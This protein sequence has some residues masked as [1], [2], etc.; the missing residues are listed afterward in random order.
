MEVIEIQID[1]QQV[2]SDG[3]FPLA[4]SPKSPPSIPD[5][6]KWVK[7][8]HA[9]ISE[10]LIKHGAILFRGFNIV[11]AQDFYDFLLAFNWPF[12][13]YTGGGGPRKVVL[14]PIET[15]TETPPNFLIPF[16]HE[17]AYITTFPG[18]VCFY[19]E[20]PTEKDGET[21]ILLSNRIYKRMASYLLGRLS[22]TFLNFSR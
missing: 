18:K 6:T 2:N 16:H 4:L 9:K 8:N 20:L 7:D 15:S 11:G 22:Y 19:C 10:Q 13:S 14:G 21:P 3:I 12:G 5:I 17:L 1:G